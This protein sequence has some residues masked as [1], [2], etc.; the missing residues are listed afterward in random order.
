M[1]SEHSGGLGHGDQIVGVTGFGQSG[2]LASVYAHH[3]LD[4]DAVV[5]AALE[6]L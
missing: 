3:G 6:L 2:D 1:E 4:A 5:G